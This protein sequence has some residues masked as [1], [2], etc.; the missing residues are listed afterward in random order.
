MV[1]LQYKNLTSLEKGRKIIA[2]KEESRKNGFL[3]RTDKRF[4]YLVR[5]NKNLRESLT[6]PRFYILK[7]HDSKNRKE[8]FLFR[9]K[10]SFYVVKNQ[11]VHTVYFC[12]SFRIDLTQSA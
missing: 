9:V 7:I 5:D 8:R 2:I 6:A 4:I 3:T 1:E 10:G 11:E 12:H